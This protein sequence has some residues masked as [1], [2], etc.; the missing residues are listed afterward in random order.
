MNNFLVTKYEN[1]E[2]VIDRFLEYVRANKRISLSKIATALA[3][4]P[5]QADRLAILLEQSGFIEL[6]YGIGEVE[7]FIKKKEEAKPVGEEAAK[8]KVV[9]LSEEVEKEVLTAE[10]LLKFFEKDITRRI[11]IAENLLKNIETAEELTPEEV[12]KIEREI[13]LALGQLAAFSEEVKQLAELEEKFYIELT[14]FKKKL[15]QVKTKKVIQEELTLFE[16]IINWIK[17]FIANL[18]QEEKREKPRK[19]RKYDGQTGVT[20]LPSE[21]FKSK[22]K[23]SVR[24]LKLRMDKIKQHYWKKRQK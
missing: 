22:K 18:K 17:N 19:K 23:K 24:V 3:I 2:T 20:F 4:T 6:H 5:V 11:A 16:K 21:S 10:N 8:R 1:V 12:N 13:D 9:E 14:D 15:K 7:A